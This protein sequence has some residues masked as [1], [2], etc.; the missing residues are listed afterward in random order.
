MAD[1]L[2]IAGSIAGLV[3]IA[4][5]I[6]TR[7]YR[8]TK[9]VKEITTLSG[10]L[11]NLELVLNEYKEDTPGANLRLHHINSC[12]ETL[13]KIRD[14]IEWKIPHESGSSKSTLEV[15][16]RKLKWP[17]S[18]SE[19]KSLLSD[20]ETHKSTINAALAGD[21]L[22]MTLRAL[23]R[24]DE[25]S[26]DIKHLKTELETRWA[27]ET[28]ITLTKQRQEIL[29][30]FG[31]VDPMTYHRTNLNLHH[32]L[33]GLWLTEGNT[34]K[35]WLHTRNSKLWLSGIPGAGKTVPAACVV[36][37]VM[38]QS[39]CTRAVAYFYCDY[40]DV[41]TKSSINIFSSIATQ[42]AKQNEKAFVHLQ[43]LYDNYHL[44]DSGTLLLEISTLAN[45]VSQQSSCFEDV[46]IVVDGLDECGTHTVDVVQSLASLATNSGSNIRA[47]FLSRDEYDIRKLLQQEFGHVEIAAHKEDLELYVAAE[48]ESRQRKVGREQLRIRSSEL[49]DHIIKSLVNGAD[50]MF[51]WAAC[52]LDLLSG[53]PT[54]AA[55]RQAL[56]S[57][58]PT[59]F[60]TYERILERL[61]ESSS[62]VQEMVQNT[63]KWILH[64]RA[65][66]SAAQICEAVSIKESNIV[67]DKESLY[68]QEDILLHCSSFIRLSSCGN[69]FE[70]AHFTVKEFLESL[71]ESSGP[72]F[73]PYSQSKDHVHP[74]LAQI[75]LTYIKLDVF[76]RD[77]I[78]D[79][80]TWE[81][82]QTQYPFRAHAVR[83][84]VSY[85]K[86]AWNHES[87]RT[88]ARELFCLSR[89]AYFL[90]WARDYIYVLDTRVFRYFSKSV[91]KANFQKATRLIC[92][93][94]VSPLHMASTIGCSE[95]CKWLLDLD[96]SI[97]QV[98]SIGTPVHCALVGAYRYSMDLNIN[99]LENPHDFMKKGRAE[100]LDLLIRRGADI[101]VPYRG[102]DGKEYSC[103]A[104]AINACMGRGVDHPLV[105]LVKAG[106]KLDFN[107]MGSLEEESLC[108]WWVYRS[109][110]TADAAR[111]MKETVEALIANLNKNSQEDRVKSALLTLA[112]Q[113][114]ISAAI[115]LVKNKTQTYCHMDLEGLEKA[116]SQ[117]VR[118]DQKDA[119]VE[120]LS[121]RRLNPIAVFGEHSETA[122]HQAAKFESTNAIV[123]LLKLGAEID[124][125]D[126]LGW[127]P[128][129]YAAASTS[130][131]EHTI[132][133]LFSNGASTAVRDR[134]GRTVWHIAAEN[135]NTVGLKTLIRMDDSK[136]K[137]HL[138]PDRNGVIPLFTAAIELQSSAFETL[139]G[140]MEAGQY[141]RTKCPN[142][143][144]L[145]HYVV[146]M[147]SIKLLQLLDDKGGELHQ[148]A[149]DGR[150][151]LHFIP[152]HVDQAIVQMLINIGLSPAMLDHDGKTPL[153]ILIQNEVEIGENVFA[154]LATD[155]TI[156]VSTKTGLSAL[157]FTVSVGTKAMVDYGFREHVFQMLLAKGSDVQTRGSNG[158][159]C[160]QMLFNLETHQRGTYPEYINLQPLKFEDFVYS[161]ATSITDIDILNQPVT[162]DASSYRLIGWAILRK[163]ESLVQL[164]FSKG[165]DANLKNLH[166]LKSGLDVNWTIA[167]MACFHDCTPELMRGILEHSQGLH[168]DTEEG[169]SL[170][171]L[172]CMEGSQSA[173]ALLEVLCD[174]G[175]DLNLQ[176]SRD[177]QTPLMLAAKSGKNNHV[178]F[179][180]QHGV[181][182]RAKD[183]YGFR[184]M[185]WVVI[186]NYPWVFEH[187][188]DLDFDWN[189]GTANF[190]PMEFTFRSTGF[191]TLTKLN[192]L[193]LAAMRGGKIITQMIIEY[194]LI[195]NVN[196]VN[197]EGFSPL[198]LAAAFGTAEVVEALL[199]AG[200]DIEAEDPS[201]RRA[202]HMAASLGKYENA[203]IL[204]A[205][206][207]SLVCDTKRMSPELYA[208]KHGYSDIVDLLRNHERGTYASPF[209]P[210]IL[211]LL[212]T[213][214]DELETFPI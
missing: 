117:A 81:D 4:D 83:Y 42:L 78:E 22:S 32:P 106:S 134:T 20:V 186:N 170:A 98:S 160:L 123:L 95:L 72:L 67:F 154:M 155:L 89:T 116:F 71:S 191:T 197:C 113:M 14:K 129:H 37:E 74:Y 65:R 168:D 126:E 119:M 152:E 131:D 201:G 76:R 202:L 11:R 10:L 181:D 46:S 43:K 213:T 183:C 127:T 132:S 39:S 86:H 118:Y 15:T 153:H 19:M 130:S 148:R 31:K 28:H 25:M 138:L 140:Q 44:K 169:Y 115:E 57:L 9:A 91:E 79:F 70:L 163:K 16:M 200:A 125:Q 63:L 109:E 179:L 30:S 12:R 189:A 209:T 66:I 196:G 75:C 21:N 38:K 68:E 34:F 53:L 199:S 141:L 104:L 29:Q 165:A 84:W 73:A 49:K 182:F 166:R 47:L 3:A 167:Q 144:G 18:G 60:K 100:V 45:T 192:I 207:C 174:Y 92:L 82:Q 185:H 35:A 133:L 190:R 149:D 62:S 1:P 88:H 137:S 204:L 23:S 212:T 61:G 136:Q 198:C 6:F 187:F 180:L 8:Y 161:V 87:M 177:S 107:V 111:D 162:W 77:V 164:L 90:S 178:R 2:S 142:G 55:K 121:D 54:D 147:N 80:D 143:I 5:T 26:K 172:A 158:L 146:S 59:L 188:K 211:L 175:V 102:I 7:I 151:G 128:L 114:K 36:E 41:Q 94:R 150:T 85:A 214:L 171:H 205:H 110:T 13:L 108:E 96:C 64:S 208:L 97:N 69:L 184:A 101:F 93:G 176:S 52:Q 135:D 105:K 56:M 145:V 40:Q 159:S 122:L 112:L 120:L 124:A 17:F 24:Q 99:G 194:S 51:R 173:C 203:Q 210:F 58:P 33:T 195:D 50:G 103:S 156:G 27:M 139:L 193:H 48:I 206:G 157:H